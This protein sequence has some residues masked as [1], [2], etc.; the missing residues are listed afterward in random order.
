ME[1]VSA[2]PTLRDE[3]THPPPLEIATAAVHRATGTSLGS[4]CLGS[5]IVASVLS[6]RSNIL[7]P[8][9]AFLTN[10]T[11]VVSVLAGVLDQ[12][13]GYALIYV[14]ITGDAFWPSARRAVGLAKGKKGGK[15]LDCECFNHCLDFT[16]LRG[17]RHPHQASPHAQLNGHG[18]FHRNGRIPVHDSLTRQSWICSSG[19]AAL[20]RR[21]VLGCASGC[22]GARG[23]VSPRTQTESS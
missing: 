3:P 2:D 1:K 4:I 11:P 13:N 15:L 16:R 5:G 8:P 22:G 7:P 19:S 9:L 10:L 6:P 23:C 12:L 18:P 17:Y 21:A 14:G 20:R